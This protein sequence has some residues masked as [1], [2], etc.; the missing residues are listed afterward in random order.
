LILKYHS[1]EE[2]KGSYKFAI[3]GTHGSG[4]TTTTDLVVKTLKWIHFPPALTPNFQR[5]EE[6]ARICPYPL[7]PEKGTPQAQLWILLNQISQEKQAEMEEISIFD[8]SVPG[9]L[10]YVEALYRRR[11]INRKQR[12]FLRHLALEW[13]K[14]RPYTALFWLS[15]LGRDGLADDDPLRCTDPKY[16]GEI[17]GYLRE[18]YQSKQFEG[19]IIHIKTRDLLERVATIVQK[20]IELCGGRL[21]NG[22]NYA[23][24][25]GVRNTLQHFGGCIA[26]EHIPPN[27]SAL[28]G[29]I[30]LCDR[31]ELELVEKHYQLAAPPVPWSRKEEILKFIK[32]VNVNIPE[33]NFYYV[34]AEEDAAA[35]LE[36]GWKHLSPKQYF[37]IVLGKKYP[38]SVEGLVS[39]TP[40]GAF[41]LKWIKNPK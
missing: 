5:R 38:V 12:D 27:D 31:R 9:Q 19:R 25:F 35:C 23:L 29:V 32:R 1:S 21:D 11:R 40:E 2:R 37:G 30:D 15:S 41:M 4:K 36:A 16:Q 3:T 26:R 20:V 34:G 22:K 24:F 17:E 39:V 7:G 18:I 8:Q 33:S 14:Q 10:A 6:A 13:E 28:K